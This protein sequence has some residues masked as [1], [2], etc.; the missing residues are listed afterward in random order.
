MTQIVGAQFGANGWQLEGTANARGFS[1]RW[2]AL[3]PNGRVLIE[4]RL[5][6][7]IAPR[8]RW[9]DS[10][11]ITLDSLITD[12]R[13]PTI[14]QVFART[15]SQPDADVMDLARAA[16]YNPTPILGL[17]ALRKLVMNILGSVWGPVGEVLSNRILGQPLG[18]PAKFDLTVFSA[19]V[20]RGRTSPPLNDRIDFGTARLIPGNK[21]GY[22]TTLG[23]TQ[24]DK[25]SLSS[26]AAQGP[27]IHDWLVQL[28]MENG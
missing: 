25:S 14:E 1:A 27:I 22:L 20:L 19:P 5:S 13:R 3:A 8:P 17:G 2:Q 10:L 7:E 23:P 16:E 11:L 18:P 28:G 6:V 15:S 24:L 4:A 12:P 9:G 26:A 21:P